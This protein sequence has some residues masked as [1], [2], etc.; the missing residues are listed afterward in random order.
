MASEILRSISEFLNFSHLLKIIFF[1]ENRLSS[2]SDEMQVL[3]QLLWR[4]A[5]HTHTFDV[6]RHKCWH[7]RPQARP[8]CKRNVLWNIT[9]ECALFG[10]RTARH[11]RTFSGIACS[12]L[13]QYIEV[14]NGDL[15]K[16]T[17]VSWMNFLDF[18]V[19]TTNGPGGSDS[20]V[21]HRH[22]IHETRVLQWRRLFSL[23]FEIISLRWLVCLPDLG[24]TLAYSL[25][26]LS[27]SPRLSL[28]LSRSLFLSLLSHHSLTDVY[29]HS[30]VIHT[31][32]N[33]KHCAHENVL[34]LVVIKRLH[35]LE[36]QRYFIS[37][38]RER[39][40]A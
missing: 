24:V 14:R 2:N 27:L 22:S 40:V 25:S 23:F 17:T 3:A 30:Y 4:E 38:P 26:L 37:Y 11:E 31:Q 1:F 29:R 20:E 18:P 10:Q 13:L 21:Q 34:R 8:A 28:S 7:C 36:C 9:Q 6:Q 16:R 19:R 32:V 33:M 5:R 15:I 12:W 39:E 35:C